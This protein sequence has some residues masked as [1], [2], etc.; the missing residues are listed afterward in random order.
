MKQIKKIIFK[1]LGMENYLRFM[2]RGYFLAYRTGWLKNNE[3]YA[4]HYYVKKLVKEGDTVID[5]GANLGYYSML[6]S[7]WVGR[8]GKVYSVEPIAIYNKIFNEKA[9]NCVNIVLYPYALGLEEKKIE[10]VSSPNT[11]FLRTG[12]PHVYD[13]QKDGDIQAQEFRFEAEMKIPAQLFADLERI[14]YIKCDIEG[15]EYIVLSNMKEII[16]KHRP[17]VQVE[18]WGDNEKNILALFD[19]LGYVPTKLHGGRQVSRQEMGNI[20]VEGDYI[21]MPNLSE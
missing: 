17:I 19:E 21:F 11:G 20:T 15:F 16:R 2:Q 7:D 9:K 8:T 18:V 3:S 10:L 4:Y 6:F 14:D 5:I 12:L 1:A 13:P